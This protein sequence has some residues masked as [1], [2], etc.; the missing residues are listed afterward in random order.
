MDSIRTAVYL[1]ACVLLLSTVCQAHTALDHRLPVSEEQL[2]TRDMVKEE[3]TNKLYF[4]HH[5]IFL[6]SS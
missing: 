6:E 1:G 3:Q 2:V 4:T 5:H